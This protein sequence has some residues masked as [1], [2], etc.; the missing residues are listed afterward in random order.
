MIPENTLKPLDARTKENKNKLKDDELFF[1]FPIFEGRDIDS[2]NPPLSQTELKIKDLTET[3]H[4]GKLMAA[5]EKLSKLLKDD[6]NRYHRIYTLYLSCTIYAHINNIDKFINSYEALSSELR[7]D[8]PRKKEMESLIY[9]IDS[10][11]GSKEQFITD[12]KIDP[13]YNY[14]ESYLPRLANLSVISLSSR[15]TKDNTV[16][17][18]I[19]FEYICSSLNHKGY[20][21]DLQSI[22]LFLG[23]SYGL[24]SNLEL[25]KTHFKKA[26]DIAYKYKLYYQVSGLYFYYAKAMD[27][28]LSSYPVEFIN[29]IKH[30]SNEIHKSFSSFLDAT[31]SNNIYNLLLSNDYIYVFYAAQGYS[32][33]EVAKT[34]GISESNVGNKYSAI[35][36][37]LGVSNKQELVDYYNK[38]R[39]LKIKK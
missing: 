15:V 36:A 7:D 21:V 30:L 9:E 5:E 13:N 19:S 16:D 22:H 17:D 34:F 39:N 29:H 18:F 6:L 4:A 31:S 12:F 27:L 33:K 32:N 8:F 23:I 38:S 24:I 14:H 11:F 35:Y 2:F 28:V 10:N 3:F 20:Y 1:R 26:L 37:E 25:M